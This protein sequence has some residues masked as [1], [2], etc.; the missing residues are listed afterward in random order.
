MEQ[1]P[2]Q[3]EDITRK[4]I[5]SSYIS[6]NLHNFFPDS[7]F[8]DRDYNIVAITP[9]IGLRWGYRPDDLKGKSLSILCNTD[10]LAWLSG[11]LVPGFFVNE[12]LTIMQ[13]SGMEVEYVV[14]GFYL[15]ILGPTSDLIILRFDPQSEVADLNVKLNE[16]RS[17]IDNF[18]YR[19]AH[20][21]RGPLATIQGL[22]YLLNLREDDS[23]VNNFIS[24]INANCKKLEERLTHLVYISK[25]HEEFTLPSF[26]LRVSDLETALRKTVE[27]NSFVNYLKLWI[28]SSHE[29]IEGYNEVLTLSVINNLLMYILSLPLSVPGNIHVESLA[30]LCVPLA[31]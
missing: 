20:D 15:G 30:S 31:L 3:P 8:L 2:N 28:S 26:Q 1:N 4:I 18:I 19:T 10:L 13:R 6:D 22:V 14:S 5:S 7:V 16:T 25:A 23:E 12:R 17:Q 11:R 24:M 21:L 29:V 9:E 27:R